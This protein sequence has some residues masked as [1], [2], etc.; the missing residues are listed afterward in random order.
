MTGKKAERPLLEE[1]QQLTVKDIVSKLQRLEAYVKKTEQRISSHEK[2]LAR[3]KD[4]LKKELKS[5]KKGMGNRGV[6]V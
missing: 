5:I 2:K 3:L 4:E 1:E 6:A